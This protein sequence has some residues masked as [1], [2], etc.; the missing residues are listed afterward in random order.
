MY[1]LQI[2]MG[3]IVVAF[4]LLTSLLQAASAADTST[5]AHATPAGVSGAL[6]L[7]TA[8]PGQ[9]LPEL[10]E[11]IGAMSYCWTP[12][13]NRD[14]DAPCLWST[15]LAAPEQKGFWRLLVRT[16]I[17]ASPLMQAFVLAVLVPHDGAARIGSYRLGHYPKP[18]KA[19]ATRYTPPE[20]FLEIMPEHR[21]I[22]VSEHFRVG[23]FLTKNQ[24]DVWPKYIALN[25][26][27]VDKLEL[28]AQELQQEGIP[29]QKVAVMSGFRTPEYNGP[30]GDGR[31][32]LSRHMYGDAADIWIDDNNDGVMDDLN[33]DGRSDIRDARIV[34]AAVDRVERHFP[35][36][37]G[38]AGAYHATQAHG[39]FTHIDTRGWHARW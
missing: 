10:I 19:A 11:P 18:P 29:V 24:A 8:M 5:P 39:P 16:G 23:D 33:R 36:F 31:G 30:G 26:Q 21:D 1:A 6:R 7:L 14:S 32:K 13:K 37:L 15:T 35:K 4:V 25:L 34:V 2:M 38:G 22:A 17:G 9:R 27:L 3:K 20:G 12:A 28:V